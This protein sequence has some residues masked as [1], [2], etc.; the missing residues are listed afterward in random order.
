M[1]NAFGKSYDAVRPFK[2]SIYGPTIKKNE[3][4]KV[5]AVVHNSLE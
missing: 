2:C 3:K 4:T 1:L 5:N